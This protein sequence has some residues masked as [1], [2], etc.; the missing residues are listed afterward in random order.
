MSF[1]NLLTKNIAVDRV[2]LLDVFFSFPPLLLEGSYMPSRDINTHTLL[3]KNEQVTNIQFA[4]RIYSDPRTK[5]LHIDE[6]KSFLFFWC[7]FHLWFSTFHN[8]TI[9]LSH[10]F[11]IF[12][13]FLTTYHDAAPDTWCILD[14]YWNS[15]YLLIRFI[16]FFLSSNVIISLPCI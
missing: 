16:V 8:H 3:Q 10:Y 11:K 15:I 9:Y 5:H 12:F 2:Y 7:K 6:L 13:L 14:S 1:V 4:C